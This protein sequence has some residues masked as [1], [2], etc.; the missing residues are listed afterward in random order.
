MKDMH[1]AQRILIFVGVSA[2]VSIILLIFPTYTNYQKFTD[3][4]VDNAITDD[5][6]FSMWLF[7]AYAITIFVTTF[8]VLY[9]A[10][11][12]SYR[13][14]AWSLLVSSVISALSISLFVLMIKNHAIKGNIFGFIV[15]IVDVIVSLVY[16]GTIIYAMRQITMRKKDQRR[17][18]EKRY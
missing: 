9:T 3:L 10:N 7:L 5:V 8:S 4:K 16:F 6:R 1:K 15:L 14:C 17:P 13:N 2:F 12:T 11:I 18:Y